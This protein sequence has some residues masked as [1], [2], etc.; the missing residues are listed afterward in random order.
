M[1]DKIYIQLCCVMYMV[2]KMY[3]VEQIEVMDSSNRKIVGH[4]FTN[5]K[6]A[7]SLLKDLEAIGSTT[8]FFVLKE[9]CLN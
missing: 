3:Y 4:E 2:K 8:Y 5:K 6:W 1:L 7:K 9:R